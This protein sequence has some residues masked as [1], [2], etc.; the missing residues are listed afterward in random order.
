MNTTSEQVCQDLLGLIGQF[1]GILARLSER[2][3]LTVMQVHALY[4]ISQGDTTM[5]HV[6]ASLHCD[7]SNVTGIVDRL[8]AAHYIVRQE[9]E[10]DRRIKSL[11]L[12]DK[13][14]DAINDI[15][16]QLPAQLGCGR[17]TSDERATIHGIVAKMIMALPADAERNVAELQ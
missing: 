2:Y 3:S 9:A 4:A 7:A 6:A 17:L 8:V 10:R 14:R 13:G 1:K 5:G 11:E 15:Y 12:T 16:S